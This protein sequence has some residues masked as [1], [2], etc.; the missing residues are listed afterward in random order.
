[1]SF[2]AYR[3]IAVV[4]MCITRDMSMTPSTH[5]YTRFRL[6]TVFKKASMNF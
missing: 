1:M 3:Y 5:D 2:L 4:R 6:L